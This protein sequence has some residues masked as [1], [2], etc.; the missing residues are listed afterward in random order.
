MRRFA[1]GRPAIG[2]GSGTAGVNSFKGDAEGAIRNAHPT[3][4]PPASQAPNRIGRSADMHPATG[5]EGSTE[6]SGAGTRPGASG[7]IV[8]LRRVKGEA[9]RRT[10][11]ESAILVMA[12][13]GLEGTTFATIAEQ[14]GMSRGLVTF[15]FKTKEQ[16]ITAALDLAGQIYEASWDRTIRKPNLAPSERLATVIAHD[17]AFVRRHPAI[18]SLWYTTWGEA[19]SQEIYR[20]NTREADRVYVSE[21]AKAFGALLGDPEGTSREARA[22]ARALNALVFGLW[23]DSHIDPDAFDAGEALDAARSVIK[24]LVPEWPGEFP[25]IALDPG[26]PGSRI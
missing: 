22:R 16:L 21:L 26:P 20:T 11:I 24:G 7:E 18:L 14:S 4:V 3:S 12:E 23:L 17:V 25:Q 10:L 1:S 19:R 13:R 15:H 9:T 5:H 6:G 2:P 8:D